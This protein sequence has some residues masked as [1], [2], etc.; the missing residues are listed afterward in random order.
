[1]I[2]WWTSL[3]HLEEW[4]VNHPTHQAIFASFHQMSQRHNF[5]LDL[6][7]RHEVSVLPAGAAEFEYINCPEKTGLLANLVAHSEGGIHD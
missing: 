3:A 4:S 5:Q 2:A 6:R 1:M 7:L